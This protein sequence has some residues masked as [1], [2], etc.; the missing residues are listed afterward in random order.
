MRKNI[1]RW[2]MTPHDRAL[3]TEVEG[4]SIRL[5]QAEGQLKALYQAL[6]EWH[7]QRSDSTENYPEYLALPPRRHWPR[8]DWP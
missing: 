2:L 1:V 5:Q 4:L 7:N 3:E 6:D 8:R